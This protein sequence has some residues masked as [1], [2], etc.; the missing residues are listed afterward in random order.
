MTN[1]NN[2]AQQVPG[3]YVMDVEH[4]SLP[5]SLYLRVTPFSTNYCAS[6][7]MVMLVSALLAAFV[8]GE[9]ELYD[10]TSIDSTPFCRDRF[11]GK[12]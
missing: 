10:K 7:A 11:N 8:S 3:H 1:K 6:I 4:Q 12:Q 5:R 2:P 9:L